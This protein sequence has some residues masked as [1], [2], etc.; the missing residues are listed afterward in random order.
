MHIA[1]LSL[2]FPWYPLV[3]TDKQNTE[4]IWPSLCMCEHATPSKGF[5][6]IQDLLL[7]HS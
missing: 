4:P 7:R 6:S 2:P 5:A 1:V 3:T